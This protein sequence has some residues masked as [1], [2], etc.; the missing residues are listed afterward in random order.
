M[1]E[2]RRG[3]PVT[4]CGTIKRLPRHMLSANPGF[5]ITTK[6]HRVENRRVHAPKID[7]QHG[8]NSTGGHKQAFGNRCVFFCSHL[9]G[10]PSALPGLPVPVASGSY[11]RMVGSLPRAFPTALAIPAMQCNMVSVSAKGIE[12]PRFQFVDFQIDGRSR[13]K[14]HSAH[15]LIGNVKNVRNIFAKIA[16]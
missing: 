7:Q 6:H 9:N 11:S 4:A 16:K 5:S 15:V 1:A 3:M 14:P 2:R 13:R 8:G 12:K 10:N